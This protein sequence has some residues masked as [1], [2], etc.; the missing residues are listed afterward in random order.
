MIIIDIQNASEVIAN[1]VGD[2]A[3]KALAHLPHGD[4]AEPHHPLGEKIG[5]MA[6]KVL[7][8]VVDETGLIEKAIINELL[9]KFADNGLKASV[10][11]VSGLKLAEKNTLSLN[12]DVNH[13]HHADEA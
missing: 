7:N 4:S 8:K 13:G 10:Y 11:S 3:Q 6:E 1:K 12:L 5:S 9:Q 2:L